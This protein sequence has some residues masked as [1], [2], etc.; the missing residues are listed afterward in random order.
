MKKIHYPRDRK[1]PGKRHFRKTA[2][3]ALC[4]C[5][6]LLFIQTVVVAQTGVNTDT[7]DAS[8]ALE[9]YST[10]K[11]ILIPRVVLTSNLN[12]ASPVTSPAT[13]LLVFNNGPNQP[14]GFYY[15]SGSQWVSLSGGSSGGDYWSL[16]GNFGTVPGTN[17]IGTNDA[18]DFLI[19]TDESER[20][21]VESDGQ[22]MIGSS[23]PYHAVDMFSVMGKTGMDYAINAFSPNVGVYVDAGY[24]NVQTLGGRYGLVSTLD[25]N[26]GFAIYGK[27]TDLTGYGIIAMGSNAPQQFLA[28]HY[29]ALI[30]L[31]DDGLIGRATG[32]A[33]TGVIATGNSLTTNARTMATGS[34]GAFTGADGILSSGTNST[35]GTGV[36]GV[37]NNITSYT[38]LLTGSGGAFQGLTTGLYSLATSLSAG[39]GVVGVGNNNGTYASMSTGSGG[40]F[41]GNDGLI[42][43]A[44]NSSTGNGVIGIGNNI[45][46]QAVH[47][48]GSG[49]AFTGYHGSISTATNVAAGTGV[50]GVGNNAGYSTLATGSG[51]AFNAVN[52]G[53]V[54]WASNTTS[55]TGVIGCGNAAA[56]NLLA[57]GSGGAFSGT[58][59]GVSGYAN[60]NIN[61]VYG[62]YFSMGSGFS[63][64]YVGYRTTNQPRKIIG[65]GSVGTIVKDTQGK[66]IALTCPEAPEVLFQ[67]YGIGQLIN[68]KAHITIDPNLAININV[69]EDHPLKVFITTEGDCNGV[70][71]TNKSANGFDVIELS[72]GTSDVPFSWQI[73]ATRANEV[74]RLEDG[75]ND[76]ADYSLRFPP[77]PGPLEMTSPHVETSTRDSYQ[78]HQMNSVTITKMNEDGSVDAEEPQTRPEEK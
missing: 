37:G 28:N 1:K 75:S 40:A 53:M 36:I 3:A 5:A 57:V 50:I 11:G 63:Y 25:T 67:D 54:A 33:K 51:G 27:N 62:G 70:Y 19:Y 72:G 14:L 38:T 26:N 61:G 52:A 44:I 45:L 42:A 31:G 68:G 20:I 43:K 29:A 8:S 55:G 60:Q 74:I 66:L 76:F 35:S 21:R 41:T 48:S 2:F 16:T 9:I 7:P 32:A 10:D 18:Q 13:G 64:A 58:T 78:E 59:C 56:P 15:W 30:G 22:V 4:F 23:A 6:S 73:V 34:G 12:N 39:T 77:A 17:Y 69:S 65:N 46:T 24:V 71:V 49:G 47:P